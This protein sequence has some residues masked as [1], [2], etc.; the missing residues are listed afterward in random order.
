MLFL[1]SRCSP[2]PKVQ[3]LSRC[4]SRACAPPRSF[5]Q[6]QQFTLVRQCAAV[7]GVLVQPF[8]V[9]LFGGYQIRWIFL[10]QAVAHQVVP[11]R[12]LRG[13]GLAQRGD[14]VVVVFRR[15]R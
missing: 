10:P 12:R 14:R 9:V 5:F 8:L 2:Q 6:Q 1:R 15:H 4:A 3:A 7:L 13:I 11:V